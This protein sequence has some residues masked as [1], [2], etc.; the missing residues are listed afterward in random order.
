MRIALMLILYKAKVVGTG[1][2]LKAILGV[3]APAWFSIFAKPVSN[4]RLV[5]SPCSNVAHVFS[6][7]GLWA[8]LCS[9]TR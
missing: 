2:V 9:G 3:T 6:G 8:V 5:N 7:L 4:A 1:L